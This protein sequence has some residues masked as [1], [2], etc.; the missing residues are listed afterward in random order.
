[1]RLIRAARLGLFS[2]ALA[3][4]D[5]EKLV[6]MQY[7][8][9]PTKRSTRVL[10]LL[11][12]P[13]GKDDTVVTTLSTILLVTDAGS[14]PTYNALSYVWGDG[15]EKKSIVCNDKEVTVTSSLHDA[16]FHLRREAEELLIWID[17]LCINQDDI[18]ERSQ[19][20]SLMGDIY[21]LAERVIV[22]LGP[23]DDETPLV[24]KLLSE[25]SKLRD[26]EAPEVSHLARE[27]SLVSNLA[28]SIDSDNKTDFPTLEGNRKKLP[29]L[30]PGSAPEWQAM[31][32]FFKRPWFTRMWTFQ[33]VVMSQYCTIYCGS[34]WRLWDHLS[35]AC[36]GISIAGFGTYLDYIDQGIH[37]IQVQRVGRLKGRRSALRSLLEANRTR[38]ATEPKD[39]V[40]ALRGVVD[41]TVADRMDTN[42]KERLGTTY[43]RAAKL[44]IEENAA[45]T[46]LGSVE[47]RRTSESKSE[48]PSWVPDWR[49]KTSVAVDLSMRRQDGSKFK[50]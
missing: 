34:Y 10:T 21:S 46:V 14:C 26:F 17:Q 12:S 47:W 31:E 23:A 13:Q 5:R 30:P 33:E 37:T 32:R 1:M 39:I 3:F 45:L 44:T 29:I 18:D 8:T 15:K 20:V 25:L 41:E 36:C 40:F 2:F 11:P 6:T 42:Y 27:G 24:W 49:Y 16:L 22:W 9:L 50:G 28:T 48:M 35:D 43:A 4:L 38:E 7:A 19:Q